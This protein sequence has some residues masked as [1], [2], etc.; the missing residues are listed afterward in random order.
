MSAASRR[1]IELAH[2]GDEALQRATF[3]LNNQRPQ[4]A[5]WIA[6]EVL[7]ADPRHAQALHILGYALLMQGRANDAIAALE[8]AARS[9]RDPELDTQLALALRQAGR[10]DDALARLER[11]IKRKPPFAPAFYELGCLLH[12]MKRY[13]EASEVLSRGLDVAPAMPEL[14]IQLGFVFLALRNYAGAKSH[15]PRRSLL[16]PMPPARC[17]ASARRIRD[18]ARTRQPSI[19]FAVA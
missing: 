19:I 13:G 11:A 9:Q 1:G 16:R 17:G 15:L 2:R 12:D 6:G 4:E 18:L 3:A 14:S 5:E 7:K 10:Q 8:P